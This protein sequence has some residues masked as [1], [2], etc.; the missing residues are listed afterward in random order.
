[1]R[2]RSGTAQAA[3]TEMNWKK[4]MSNQFDEEKVPSHQKNY[5]NGGSGGKMIP[6]EVPPEYFQYE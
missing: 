3:K 1:M 6:A 5:L 2:K 4:S